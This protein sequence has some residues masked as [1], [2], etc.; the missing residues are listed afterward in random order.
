MRILAISAGVL[1][2]AALSAAAHEDPPP[3]RIAAAP[4]AAKDDG[5]RVVCRVESKT[6]ER[7]P[8]RTCATKRQWDEM[9]RQA[10]DW[11]GRVREKSGQCLTC[12]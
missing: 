1:M 6:G 10:K 12:N 11:M 8:T 4:M 9:E 7:I 5:D 3:N 2:M